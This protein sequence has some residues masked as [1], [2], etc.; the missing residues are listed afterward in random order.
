M[1]RS[2]N[3]RLAHTHVW[4]ALR[5]F[6]AIAPLTAATKSASAN[7]M[8]GALPPSSSETRLTV[9]ADLEIRIC[10]TSVDPVNEILRTRSSAKTVS[11][12]G[13]G[14]LVVTMLTT[15]GGKPAS[16]NKLA[17]SSAESGVCSA[18]LQMVVQPAASAG[19]SLRV[20]IAVGKFQG[21]IITATPTGWRSTRIRLLDTEA[22]TI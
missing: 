3:I 20:S 22:G 5:N 6:E 9:A 2:T 18:G 12:N 14:L 16:V 8:N 4:P 15:P 11:E 1:P 19:P 17:S 10:P 21:V 13:I 7:T